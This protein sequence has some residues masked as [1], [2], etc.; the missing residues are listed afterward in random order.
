MDSIT[1]TLFGLTLYGALKTE[2]ETKRYNRAL[3]VT[4]I[5]A[6]QIPDI[7]VVSQF[8]DTQGLYQMW[9]RGIT[10]SIFI[11][12]I[13]AFVFW[14]LAWLLFRIKDIRLFF[15]AWLAVF[16]HV[17]S[18]L[19][20]AWGTGYLEPFSKIRITFGT[21]PII[22]FVFW[23]IMLGAF[24]IAKRSSIPSQKV[25]RTAWLLV[26][27]HIAAQS[28]CGY[29]IYEQHEENYEKIALSANFIPYHFTVIGK[30]D[31]IVEIV[32]DN[33]FQSEKLLYTL[34]SSENADLDLLFRE[35]PEA[36]TLYEWAPFV[37]IVDND[38]HLG[39]YDPRFYRNGQSFLFEYIE[40]KGQLDE[41]HVKN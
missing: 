17:T 27:V 25:F 9:H 13:W 2:K 38:K 5:G 34:Q 36:K 8:W 21:I 32:E 40:K 29:I 15:I 39:L 12:P 19:F 28:L 20:N 22:D 10:H 23:I 7:D 26:A 4:A 6:S 35:R 41:M 24:I 14:G 3:L 16:I 33:L 37:V 1:H 30:K 18:D 31:D 11:T